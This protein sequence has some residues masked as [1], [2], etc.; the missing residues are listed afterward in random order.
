[1]IKK[2]DF[3]IEFIDKFMFRNMFLIIFLVHCIIFFTFLSS[4]F[5]NFKRIYSQNE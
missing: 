3:Y 2:I 1:M 5:I 4:L